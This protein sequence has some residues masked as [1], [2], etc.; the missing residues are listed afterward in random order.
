MARH[1]DPDDGSFRRSL[2]RA[3]AGGL[4]ALVVTFAITAAFT[5]FGRDDGSGGPAVTFTGTPAV[6]AQT[7]T[8]E[9]APSPSPVP[10]P[11]P[12]PRPS[13]PAPTPAE[14]TE[15]PERMVTVQVLYSPATQS[16]AEEAAAVLREM[17]Y[18]VVAVN[19]THHTRDA[20]TVLASPGHENA[21]E[22]LRDSDGR[23]GVIEPNTIFN[24][25]VHLHVIVGPDFTT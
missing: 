23:F 3:A 5:Q 22:A 18:D 1:V 24:K 15:P 9:P 4:V 13:P 8:V 14:V 2:L 20:T 19:S 11:T 7:E 21:A 25:D 12:V 10:S 16:Q 6:L 17:G